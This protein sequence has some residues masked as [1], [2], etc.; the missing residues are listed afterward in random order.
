M[1][2][3]AL[4]RAIQGYIRS[5][6]TE[7]LLTGTLYELQVAVNNPYLQLITPPVIQV[8]DLFLNIA[9]GFPYI[10]F[11]SL[12]PPPM[13][14]RIWWESLGETTN[15]SCLLR[16]TVSQQDS[17]GRNNCAT[18]SAVADAGLLPSPRQHTAERLIEWIGHTVRLHPTR[19]I[20]DLELFK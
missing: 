9:L 20:D 10:K 1:L 17:S 8:P 13:V 18:K 14:G 4:W 3:R 19:R 5:S 12:C 11:W 2:C 16:S 7:T 6:K 15:R